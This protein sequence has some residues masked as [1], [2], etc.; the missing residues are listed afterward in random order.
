MAN[1]NQNRNSKSNTNDSSVDA[2]HWKQRKKDCAPD[3]IFENDFWVDQRIQPQ[4]YCNEQEN[5]V[6]QVRISF[7]GAVNNNRLIL[8]SYHCLVASGK[9]YFPIQ[10]L[11][12]NCFLETSDTSKSRIIL[13]SRKRWR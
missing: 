13:P 12:K 11:K 6:W 1:A 8:E 4:S 3:P 5:C 10:D 7:P 2:S 9:Q